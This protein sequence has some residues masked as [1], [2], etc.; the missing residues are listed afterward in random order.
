MT[1]HALRIFL[2]VGAETLHLPLQVEGVLQ[3]APARGA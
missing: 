3:H 1:L 2:K